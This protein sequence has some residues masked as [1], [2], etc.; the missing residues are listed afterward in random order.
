[1]KI[2]TESPIEAKLRLEGRGKKELGEE[3]S[4]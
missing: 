2:S 3:R 4:L 1:M